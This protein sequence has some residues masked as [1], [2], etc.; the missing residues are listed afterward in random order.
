[1]KPKKVKLCA[2]ARLAVPILG[3]CAAAALSAA[4]AETYYYFVFS[5]PVAGHE[6]EYNKWYDE[7]H[8]ADIVA[9]PGYMTAQR[10]LLIDLRGGDPQWPKY[11]GTYKIVTDNLKATMGATSGPKAYMSPAFDGKTNIG[12]L[13]RDLGPEIKGVGGE[14][15]GAKSGSKQTYVE[16]VFT[17]PVEGREDEFN[18]WEDKTYT[19]A[20]LHTPGVVGAERMILQKPSTR[21]VPATK[22]LT[23]FTIETSD[24]AT[25]RKVLAAR[26][27]HPSPALDASVGREYV[28][29][30]IGPVID[31][32]KVRAAGS[33]SAR[34]AK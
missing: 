6:D 11:L 30:A 29:R 24:I 16:F 5:N 19:P 7:Q 32:D 4:P 13:Y 27:P 2:I 34:A 18:T 21:G 23:V 3:L 25:V 20:V 28:F 31:G 10:F 12:Y 17:G 15:H 33:I 9:R 1:M 14:P 22:Y 8:A 26:L